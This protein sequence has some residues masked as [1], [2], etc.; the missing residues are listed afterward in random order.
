MTSYLDFRKTVIR[1]VLGFR[2]ALKIG[3]KN[4]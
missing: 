4:H 1:L 3:F 2:L